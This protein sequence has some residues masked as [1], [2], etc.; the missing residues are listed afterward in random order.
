MIHRYRKVIFIRY[1][2]NRL[3][4]F[5]CF[6]NHTTTSM[7]HAFKRNSRTRCTIFIPWNSDEN[8]VD[9][10]RKLS[11]GGK[12]IERQRKLRVKR[13]NECCYGLALMFLSCLW[14]WISFEAYFRLTRVPCALPNATVNSHL[15]HCSWYDGQILNFERRYR[16]FSMKQC[17]L[18]VCWSSTIYQSSF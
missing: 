3:I 16:G 13:R 8:I 7:F 4:K 11:A 6:H 17:D 18:K 10:F 1:T 14:H 2:G 5:I 9:R 12:V 15:A